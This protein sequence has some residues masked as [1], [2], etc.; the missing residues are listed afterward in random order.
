[1]SI[2]DTSFIV[3]IIEFNQQR[4]FNSDNHTITP[5]VEEELDAKSYEDILDDLQ[6][7]IQ[8][9]ERFDLDLTIINS[10][11]FADEIERIIQNTDCRKVDLQSNLSNCSAQEILNLE[12]GEQSC[13]FGR[14]KDEFIITE[15]FEAYNILHQHTNGKV[16]CLIELIVTG[17]LD[18]ERKDLVRA[19]D[20]LFL[21][22]DKLE[23]N[24]WT[25]INS[26]IER[27]LDDRI[28]VD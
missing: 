13:Y 15:D 20:A 5:Q 2:C 27:A 7:I 11:N 28:T 3:R 18:D 21:P 25:V 26:K 19:L 10:S 24:L 8:I 17:D 4:A 12:K 14:E 23:T 22:E 1:M 9:S 6:R 16:A